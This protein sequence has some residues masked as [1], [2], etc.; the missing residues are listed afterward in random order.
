MVIKTIAD[1]F[2]MDVKET[3]FN[4]YR[5]S[6]DWKPYHHDAAAFNS[7]KGIIQAKN[8]IRIFSSKAWLSREVSKS[9]RRRQK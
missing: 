4:R 2:N 1:F 7:D 6:N 5:N 3:R 8:A 9:S